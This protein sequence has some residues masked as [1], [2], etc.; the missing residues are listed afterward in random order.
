MMVGWIAGDLVASLFV[1]RQVRI[2]TER[3]GVHTYSG[4]LSRWHGTNYRVL[5][6]VTGL[7]TLVF[8]G[9]YAAAQLSAGSKALHVL[10]GWEY[11]SGAVIG[12][13]IV[14]LYSFAGGI[15]ASIW[16]DAAQSIVMIIAMALLMMVALEHLGGIDGFITQLHSVAPDYLALFPPVEGFG[17]WL[18]PLLFVAGWFFAGF[19][20]V[21]QPHI[22]IRFMAL[23]DPKSLRRAR[24]YYYS[25]F[26]LFWSA[27]ILVGLA[28]RLLLPE[29]ASF[30]AE[31]ALPTLAQQLL[32]QILVGVVLAGIFAA[33]MSTADSLILSCAAALTRDFY[34]RKVDHYLLTKVGTLAVT[35]TA[36]FIALSGNRSVYQLVLDSWGVLASA[37]APLLAVYALGYRVSERLALTMVIG[38]ITTMYGWSSYGPAA[39]YAVAPAMVTG[40]LIFILGGLL[41]RTTAL[42][43]QEG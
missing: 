10:F 16:T 39:V 21:G 3:T 4:L 43:Q 11:W 31:L 24:F 37:F 19:G 35:A 14:L 7:I 34:W 33:T 29:V 28:A 30:D 22:M 18:G 23:D 41:R 25:W 2:A 26:A 13:G 38:G 15:R 27:A 6:F 1:H 5:R 36:L 32:P 9:T 8:L 40:V 42:A 20:V 17:S 12:A